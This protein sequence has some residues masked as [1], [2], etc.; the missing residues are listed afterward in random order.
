MLWISIT[1]H[2]VPGS[3]LMRKCSSVYRVSGNIHSGSLAAVEYWSVPYL[4]GRQVNL[5]WRLDTRWLTSSWHARY[6]QSGSPPLALCL[7]HLA[8]QLIVKHTGDIHGCCIASWPHVPFLCQSLLS[9]C[10]WLSFKPT[11]S[12]LFS[13]CLYN[14]HWE[15]FLYDVLDI[16]TID[17][18]MYILNVLQGEPFLEK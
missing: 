1:F 18:F 4:D 5:I 15:P 3:A 12:P 16:Q 10:L 6:V 14:R 9:C 2:G 7:L 13:M 8:C 17:K 11:L